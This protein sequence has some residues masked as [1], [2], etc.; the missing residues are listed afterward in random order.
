M[1]ELEYGYVYK[2]HYKYAY[3]TEWYVVYG[4][5]NDNELLLSSLSSHCVSYD[6][7][8]MALTGALQSEI[9]G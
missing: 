4:L 1:D 3:L 6:R 5:L 7:Q 2:P 8:T 9:W